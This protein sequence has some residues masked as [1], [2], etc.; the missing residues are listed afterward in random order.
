VLLGAALP[1]HPYGRNLGDYAAA[2][3]ALRRDDLRAYARRAC[4]PGR[5]A[6]LL[7]GDLDPA[8]TLAELQKTLGALPS[9]DPPEA[10]V[11]PDLN[12]AL[13]DRRVQMQGESFRLLAEK[14]VPRLT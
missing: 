14:V 2:V 10:P 8:A 7:V 4:A 11:L 9:G 3:D 6:I 1:G 12:L 5:M 13:G